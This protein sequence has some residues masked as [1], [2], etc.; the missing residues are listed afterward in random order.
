MCFSDFVRAIKSPSL[1]EVACHWNEVR[2][3]CAMPDWG[4]IRPSRIA[5]QLPVIWSYRFEDD[6]FVGRLAGDQVEKVFGMTFRGTPMK[7]L[8]P[9]DQY[10]IVFGRLRRV[11]CEPALYLEKGNVFQ[12][13]EHYGYGERIAMPLSR[14]GATGDGIVGATVYEAFRATDAQTVRDEERWYTL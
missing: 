10:P 3:A 13:V 7:D 11:V 9:T 12:L 2:G 5:Q 6:A 4:D 8:Y 14:D 1:R